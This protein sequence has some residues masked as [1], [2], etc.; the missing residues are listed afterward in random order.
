MGLGQG[1]RRV[2]GCKQ[3]ISEPAGS[4]ALATRS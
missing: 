1:D 4:T 3:L 2:T